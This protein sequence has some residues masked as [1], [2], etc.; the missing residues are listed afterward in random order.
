MLVALTFFVRATLP[1]VSVFG[2]CNHAWSVASVAECYCSSHAESSAAYTQPIFALSSSDEACCCATFHMDIEAPAFT[3]VSE[4]N[5]N[6]QLYEKALA[7]VIQLLFD[8]PDGASTID[9]S[10]RRFSRASLPSF[11]SR[12]TLAL[13]SIL[14][15]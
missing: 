3:L 8:V 5:T 6:A 4:S 2:A 7:V 1:M 11:S 15:I 10:N 13:H 14:L 9:H 12:H